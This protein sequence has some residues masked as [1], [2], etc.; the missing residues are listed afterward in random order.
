MA[1]M[2]V[3]TVVVVVVVEAAVEVVDLHCWIR[4]NEER[5]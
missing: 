5:V 1:M 3:V 4:F 2:M